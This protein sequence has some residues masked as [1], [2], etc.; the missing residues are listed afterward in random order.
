MLLFFSVSISMNLT[1]E[2]KKSKPNTLP[3]NYQT[4]QVI[5]LKAVMKNSY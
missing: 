5:E 4:L 1:E 2:K 3:Q